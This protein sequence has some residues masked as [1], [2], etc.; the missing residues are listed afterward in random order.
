VFLS[1]ETSGLEIHPLLSGAAAASNK[2]EEDLAAAQAAHELMTLAFAQRIEGE[3]QSGHPEVSINDPSFLLLWRRDGYK[4]PARLG[5][6][7][8]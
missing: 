5:L 3:T 7:A 4:T 8:C 2:S 1:A 6:L